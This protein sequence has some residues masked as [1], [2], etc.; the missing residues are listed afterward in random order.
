MTGA[1]TLVPLPLRHTVYY[2]RE[3]VRVRATRGR[4][5]AADLVRWFRPWY[6][7]LAPD[8]SPL[9]DEIPWLTFGAIRFLERELPD[10]MRAFEYGTGGSTIFLARR[11][12]ELVTVEH[13][14]VWAE[15]VRAAMA[16]SASSWHLHVVPPESGEAGKSVT[17]PTDPDAFT[18]GDPASRARRFETYARTIEPYADASLDIVLVDGRARPSCL[19]LAVPKVRPGGVLVLDDSER[20]RY[21]RAIADPRLSSWERT[22]YSGPS[23]YQRPFATSTV[24]RRPR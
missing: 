5:S 19:A 15:L 1:R 21:Q 13:D 2:A 10:G 12:A 22:D 16:A 14:P 23:P 24:W 9:A 7:S 20:E 3:A 17:D 11:A 6:R 8:A 4:P 18:S